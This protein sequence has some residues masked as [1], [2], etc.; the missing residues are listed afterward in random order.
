MTGLIRRI[1]SPVDAQEKLHLDEPAYKEF[2]QKVT[3]ET[4]RGFII[5]VSIVVMAAL[6]AAATFQLFYINQSLDKLD[7]NY[8]AGATRA[9]EVK[10]ISV[11]AAFC[12]KLPESTTV[13]KTQQCIEKELAKEKK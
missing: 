11:L 8:V 9:A 7:R 13:A 1:G 12:A 3:N 5:V 10:D 2:F 4:F 6:L